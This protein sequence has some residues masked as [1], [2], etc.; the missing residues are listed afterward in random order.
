MWVKKPPI[1]GLLREMLTKAETKIRDLFH[2]IPTKILIILKSNVPEIQPARQD[3]NPEIQN[4]FI[5]ITNERL[6]QHSKPYTN[7]KFSLKTIF[8]YVRKTVDFRNRVTEI[9]DI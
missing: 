8:T 5:Q 1:H 6:I 2:V 7:R 9:R 3:L 4:N